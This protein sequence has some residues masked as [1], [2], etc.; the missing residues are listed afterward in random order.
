MTSDEM[1]IVKNEIRDTIQVVVNGKIDKIATHLNEQDKKL[2]EHIEKM[3]PVIDGLA[4]LKT[5]NTIFKW[6][7]GTVIMLGA[8]VAILKGWFTL[9]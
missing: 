4:F 9:R 5:G 3:Q 1:E 7:G 8:L 2:D 6:V